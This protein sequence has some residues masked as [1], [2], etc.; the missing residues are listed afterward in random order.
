MNI[1]VNP[2]DLSLSLA[3]PGSKSVMQRALAAASLSAGTSVLRAPARCA[4]CEAAASVA[5]ALGAEVTDN[6][7][8]VRVRGF[9]HAGAPM[10]DC[11]ESGLAVRMF[12]PVAALR[13]G[14]TVL[15]GHRTLTGRPLGPIA[16]PL[17]ALGAE[18][19]TNGGYVP[20]R[21][22]GALSGGFAEVDGSSSSQFLTGLLTALPAA[23]RDSELRVLGL[24]SAPYVDLTV[25]TL[26]R[27]GI[28]IENRGYETFLIP[29]GQAFHP[30]DFAVEGDWSGA[31]FP[32]VAGATL[33]R[34]GLSVTGLDP[35]SAQADRAIL[36]ALSAA[37]AA[38]EISGTTVTCRPGALK[39]F[40]FD[41][42]NCPDLF[43]PLAA[44]ASYCATPSTFFGAARLAHK[45]SD[46]ALAIA[47]EFAELGIR[48]DVD[49]DKMT[50]HP[51]RALSGTADSRGDH[52]MAMAEALLAAGGTGPVRIL[53]ASCV[54]K[55]WPSF[56]ED[57]AAVGLRISRH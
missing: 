49:G 48:V 57:M 13:E 28:R 19:D 11:G 42:T 38:V 9:A 43:P 45:E 41:A 31:A 4:D 12:S 1:T 36:E 2:S 8:E 18:C 29:G 22:K 39:G 20:V 3:A 14:E 44:L 6:G 24:K 54:A 53:G 23:R 37:G 26:A 30:A 15:N 32:L 16:G 7:T 46:R 52:R 27:F 25:A 34:D 56:F 40:E 17:K 5:A 55:S 50:V 35:S 33:A 10:V 47:R 51:G 21:V